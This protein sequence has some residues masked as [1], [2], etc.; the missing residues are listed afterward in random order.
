MK[1]KAILDVLFEEVACPLCDLP[2]PGL[3]PNCRRRFA[4]WG[5]YELS[6]IKGQAR[7]HYG[8][9]AR[10]LMVAYKQRGRYS[11]QKAL[12]GLLLQDLDL[13]AY[14]YIVPIPGNPRNV[15]RRG[16][17]AGL[18]LAKALSESSGIPLA[19]ILAHRGR[20]EQK[21]AGYLARAKNAESAFV[22][23]SD[24]N[25]RGKRVLLFDDI[26][27]TGSSLLAGEK[28]LS[29]QGARVEFL[30][31]FHAGEDR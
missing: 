15:R 22:L 28:L 27:T 31:L 26:S 6:H 24:P 14:D 11:A 5:A 12:Q 8:S 4:P 2:E 3:C 23:A 20:R 21:K 1:L 19:T 29:R 25:L 13:A 17:D 16:F 7:Y 10:Q 30:V 9:A 18:A